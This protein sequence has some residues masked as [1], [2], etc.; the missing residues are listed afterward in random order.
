MNKFKNME[1]KELSPQESLDLIQSMI[2]RARQR[3][4]D[5]SFYFLLWG[6]VVMLASVTHYV[7]VEYTNFDRPY[8]GWALTVPAFVVSMIYGARQGKKEGVRNYTDGIYAW[9]WFMLGI[10]MF[11]MVFYGEKLGWQIVPL[12]MLMGGVGTVVSGAMLKFRALQ[13]GGAAFWLLSILAFEV[14][15][16]MQMLLMAVA[17]L[18]GYL[19]PGY[20]MKSKAKQDAVQNA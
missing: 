6:W 11:T 12:T 18:I 8:I 10:S 13:I 2:G 16:G 5:N 3:F 7:V 1:E 14:G 9:M 20:L 19:I 15:E 4:T 17:V